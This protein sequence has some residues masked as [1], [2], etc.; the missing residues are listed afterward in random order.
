MRECFLDKYTAS[1]F[2]TC[3]HRLLQ[4]MAGLPIEFYVH[5]LAKPMVCHIPS[6]NPLHWQQKVHDDLI[7]DKA[8]GI[9][10]KVQHDKP[11]E[12]CHRIV[13]TRKYDGS[14]HLT[15]DLSPL[16]KLCK[17]ETH[18]FE[19]PFHLTRRVPRNTCKTLTGS[20]NG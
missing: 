19:A 7:L 4:G 8:I 16:N 18:A 15:E 20:L 11:T 5:P 3:P 13:I 12:C 6:P 17:R 9:L 10:E 14:P 2:N 1:T